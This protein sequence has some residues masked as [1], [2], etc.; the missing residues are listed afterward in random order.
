MA[1]R[2]LLTRRFSV[3]MSNDA[4]RRLGRFAQDSD[5]TQDEALTFLL[6]NFESVI[7]AENL[8]ARLRLFRARLPEKDPGL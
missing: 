2:L 6:E 7:N 3:A 8:S 1:Q 5:L 4:C